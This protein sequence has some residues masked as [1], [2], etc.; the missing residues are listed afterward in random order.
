M[1][2][3]RKDIIDYWARSPEVEPVPE[4]DD[5]VLIDGWAPLAFPDLRTLSPS[6]KQ[7]LR[8]VLAARPDILQFVIDVESEM[9]CCGV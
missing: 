5:I 1:N 2:I 3:T 6:E 9:Q 8:P 7:R 4:G